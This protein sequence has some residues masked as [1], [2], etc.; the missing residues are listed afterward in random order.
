MAV[1]VKEEI[2]LRRLLQSLGFP[3]QAPM[4]IFFDRQVV[5]SLVKNPKYHKRTKHIETKY[6]SIRE[7]YNR[8]QIDVHYI[9]TIKRQ[10]ADLLTK[11]LPH[12]LQQQLRNL[13][14]LV[15]PLC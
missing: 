12:E 1:S 15:S 13:Q 6:F 14:G 5:I 8:K 3:Q 11:A 9:H 4:I 7:K 10:L 2:W